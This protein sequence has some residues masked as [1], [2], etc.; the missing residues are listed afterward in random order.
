MRVNEAIKA[1]E[2]RLVDE[3]GKQIGVVN[4]KEAIQIARERGYDLVEVAPNV[5][6]PVCRIMDYGKYKYQLEKKG[7]SKK[8]STVKEIKIRPQISD[9]DLQLKVKHIKRFLEDGDKA[10][11]TLFFRGREIVHSEMGMKVFDKIKALL[12]GF[13]HKIEQEPRLEGNSMSMIIAPGKD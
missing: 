12:V 6:P 5:S 11:I 2:V 9:H 1:K 7:S 8:P 3:N 13:A 10:R 4:T